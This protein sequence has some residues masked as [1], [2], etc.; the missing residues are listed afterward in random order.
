MDVG[1]GMGHP[2]RNLTID[3]PSKVPSV[4]ND[5]IVLNVKGNSLNFKSTHP[6][7]QISIVDLTGK[8]RLSYKMSV[9]EDVL[10]IGHLENGVY[11]VRMSTSQ[12]EYSQK[13]VL[14]RYGVKDAYSQ[15]L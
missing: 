8:S 12:G 11:I 3:F 7:N 10:D 9:L 6:L 4:L 2:M 15:T 1:G 5:Y 13:I 14:V